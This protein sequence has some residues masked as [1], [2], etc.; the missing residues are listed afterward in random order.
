MT[1]FSFCHLA[2]ILFDK[3][4]GSKRIFK[5]NSKNIFRIG[6]HYTRVLFSFDFFTN[7][8]KSSVW[9]YGRCSMNR[10]PGEQTAMTKE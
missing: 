4:R 9:L 7:F 1:G 5:Q 8:F 6:W 3:L 2:Y 10:Q